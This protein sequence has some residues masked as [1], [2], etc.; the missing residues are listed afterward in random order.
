[1]VGQ[2]TIAVGMGRVLGTIALLMLVCGPLQADQNAPGDAKDWLAATK[3]SMSQLNYRG[4]VA[5]LKDNR[6]ES[7][8]V[9]HRVSDGIEQERLLSVNSP[10]REVVRNAEKVTCYFPDSRSMVVEN[11]AV[12]QSFLLD[13]PKDLTELTKHYA[14]SL[15]GGAHVAQRPARLVKVEPLDE[16]RYGRRFWV[17]V[18]SKLLLKFELI[19]EHGQVVEQ[20]VFN[21]LSVEDSM[22]AEELAAST[23]VNASWKVKQHEMLPAESLIWT[24]EGVPD[25]FKI[26]SYTRIKRGRDNRT[27]DHI[28]LSDGL[29][30]VSIYLD[31]TL[32]EFFTVH[33]RK[34]GA[35]NSYTRKL[36]QYLVTVMGEVPAK[37]VQS[38]GNGIRQQ[39]PYR[40]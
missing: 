9:F 35:I 15:G 5:Y 14:L 33:P 36:D 31:D 24:L 26:V 8:K 16:Y 29:S 34:V 32:N 28:L 27:V 6:I 12:R 40:K 18:E 2:R 25:G 19:D 1:M 38:I 7:L 22:P 21:S 30:S 17:D 11:K 10:M 23:Q 20:M 3:R 39:N 4:M 13:L 37:T